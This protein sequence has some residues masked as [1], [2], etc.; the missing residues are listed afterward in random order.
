MQSDHRSPG[1]RCRRSRCR[2]GQALVEFA[3][4]AFVLYFLFAGILTF[5]QLFYGAQSLQPAADT[6]AS[7][8]ARIPLPATASLYDVLYST[9]PAYAQ[10]RSQVFDQQ[11]LYVNLNSIPRANRSPT[12]SKHGQSSIRCSCR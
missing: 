6:A 8:L 3:I 11:Y 10:V 5:G 9:D 12:G 1:S 7:E 2:R 4:V